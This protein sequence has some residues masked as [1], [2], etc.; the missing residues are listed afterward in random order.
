M[1]KVVGSSPIIR[2]KSASKW[3]A[4]LPEVLSLST[5]QPKREA[6]DPDFERFLKKRPLVHGNRALGPDLL[7]Q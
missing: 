3:R 4:L 2:S 6:R 7:L 5:R 1:Q